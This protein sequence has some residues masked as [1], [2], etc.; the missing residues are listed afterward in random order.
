MIEQIPQNGRKPMT[1]TTSDAIAMEL[2]FV[3]GAP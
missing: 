3:V 1:E 2:V